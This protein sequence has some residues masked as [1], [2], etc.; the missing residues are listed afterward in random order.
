MK[1]LP[2]MAGSNHTYFCH[3]PSCKGCAKNL[4]LAQYPKIYST[5]KLYCQICRSNP[6]HCQ[7]THHMTNK[8][9]THI[10]DPGTNLVVHAVN[11]VAS[12]TNYRMMPYH[13]VNQV[14]YSP[15]NMVVMPAGLTI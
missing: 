3:H 12:E 1:Y 6:C 14:P 11:K 4:T 9:G 8:A 10:V 7:Q 13:P 2:G 5:S 15:T